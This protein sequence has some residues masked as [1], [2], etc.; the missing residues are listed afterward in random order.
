MASPGGRC[1]V[2][3][4]E[5]KP[6][7]SLSCGRLRLAAVLAVGA[8]AALVSMPAAAGG[9]ASV[10]D[11]AAPL[12]DAVVN[13]S[14]TQTVGG[15]SSAVPGPK[16]PKD[17]PFQQFF[18][19]FNGDNGGDN[20]PQRVQSLGSGFVIDQSGL[21]VTNNHVIEGAD[22][23]TANFSNGRKLTATLVG[24][25][26][27]T[28]LAL[29]KVKSDTPLTSVGF[30]DSGQIRVGDW[31]MAIGNPFGLGGTVTLGIV[32]ARN[33]DIN[34]GPYDDFIQTD[35]HQP[36]NG[37]AAVRHGAHHRHQHGDHRR[38]AVDR[39][40]VAVPAEIAIG[41]IDGFASSARRGAAGGRPHQERHRRDRS[42]HGRGCQ[43]ALVAG[44]DGK[45]PA[46]EAGIITGGV[47]LGFNGTVV[48]DACAA[49]HG[50]RPADWQGSANPG[51]AR[52]QAADDQRQTRAARGG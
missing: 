6:M 51:S 52:G 34:S 15:S 37:R 40:R 25:D 50:R 22:E 2:V 16:L 12:L 10:A 11:V 24:H 5:V 13:I 3:I 8:V 49:A 42:R 20:A 32:S 39:H 28:D 36:G 29:L 30:G 19:E 14:T 18:D 38:P 4:Q 31:V 35:A 27:K 45:G 26:E 46:A 43:G 47:I 7:A 1:R 21:I 33:R 9:P 41:V 44:V 23:I 48:G 17:S